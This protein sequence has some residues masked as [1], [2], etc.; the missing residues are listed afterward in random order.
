MAQAYH[1]P[2]QMQEADDGPQSVRFRAAAIIE[3]VRIRGPRALTARDLGQPRRC[4]LT[5]HPASIMN[6]LHWIRRQSAW[7]RLRA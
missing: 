4:V 6:D 3:Q 5:V 2:C 1:H 7:I